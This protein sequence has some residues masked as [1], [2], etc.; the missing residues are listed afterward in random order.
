MDIDR[1]TKGHTKEY[2]DK[3]VHAA[4]D[5]HLDT[6]EEMITEGLHPGV[7]HNLA[8]SWAAQN[9]HLRVVCRLMDDPRVDPTG[10]NNHALRWAAHDN[11]FSIMSR[12]LRDERV[13]RSIPDI[14]AS[15]WFG[16][17]TDHDD[18][19]ERAMTNLSV[20]MLSK[21]LTMT[22]LK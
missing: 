5:G 14:K 18:R 7:E 21:G 4:A 13:V 8:L 16:I 15:S 11:N 19:H 17:D 1:D 2:I 6:I 22:T 20:Y 3:F 9:G 12:L 10:A